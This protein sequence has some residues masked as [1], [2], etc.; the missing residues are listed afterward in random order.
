MYAIDAATRTRIAPLLQR[1]LIADPNRH[2]A[3]LFGGCLKAF[4]ARDLIIEPDHVSGLAAAKA[5]EP[6]LIITEALEDGDP[7][8]LVRSIRRSNLACRKAPVIVLTTLATVSAIK[9]AKD[10]GAHEF[11]RKPFSYRDVMRRLDHISRNPR[12]WVEKASYAGPDRR[13]FNSG[14]A[15]R[16]LSDRLELVEKGVPASSLYLVR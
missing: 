13:Q 5:V 6:T 11:L 9:M 14:A 10:A 3:S 2:M 7:F 4:G 16:R 12:P 8:S 1:V 15:K